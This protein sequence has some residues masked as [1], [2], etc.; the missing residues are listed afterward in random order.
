MH[1]GKGREGRE[2]EREGTGR[3]G[4]ALAGVARSADLAFDDMADSEGL[5]TVTANM[6]KD[7]LR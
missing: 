3:I 2:K 6:S 1:K 7:S 5:R 4:P